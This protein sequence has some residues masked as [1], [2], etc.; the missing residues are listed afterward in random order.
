M[1]IKGVNI[2]N[3]TED[4]IVYYLSRVDTWLSNHSNPIETAQNIRDSLLVR[5]NQINLNQYNIPLQNT[6]H[7]YGGYSVINRKS[8]AK[9]L[10]NNSRLLNKITYHSPYKVPIQT[11]DT[12]TTS[13]NHSVNILNSYNE[14]NKTIIVKEKNNLELLNHIRD[15]NECKIEDQINELEFKKLII[16]ELSNENKLS[17]DNNNH[18]SN[19]DHNNKEPIKGKENIHKKEKQ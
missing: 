19:N 13:I 3:M 9:N 14:T 11:L 16:K 17:R 18:N 4:E 10:E 2:S 6:G 5:Y 7:S 15:I 8:I 12:D 1:S